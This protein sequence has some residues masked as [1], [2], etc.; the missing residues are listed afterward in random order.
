MKLDQA[1]RNLAKVISE[2]A[3]RNPEFEDRLLDAIG[4]SVTK[5]GFSS[6]LQRANVAKE[7]TTRGR[8]RRARAVLDP[9]QMVQESE[10][11]LREQLS[12]LT[13]EQLKDIVA[14]YGM[15][16]SKLVMK[17]RIRERIVNH[18]VDMA[19]SRSRKGDAF[20]S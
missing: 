2:E 14:D 6:S 12:V 5:D 3:R 4:L 9:I 7:E 17:W 10:E 1:M 13:V 11:K 16:P 8:N 15:D 19:N 20:R 18:I